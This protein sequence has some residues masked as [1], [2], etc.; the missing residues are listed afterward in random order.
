MKENFAISL[1][2]TLRHEGGYSND[3]HDPGG[4]TMRGVTWREYNRYR[5]AKGLPI[6]PVRECT[7]EEMH[8]IYRR[9]YWD[10]MNCDSLPAGLDFAIFDLAVNNGV[11]RAKQF[12][13]RAMQ[14]TDGS[15]R[16]LVNSICDQRLAFDKGLRIWRVFG[17]GWSR[18][19]AEVRA[20]SLGMAKLSPVPTAEA[21][22]PLRV[23]MI[24]FVVMLLQSKLR[25]KGYPVGGIDGIFGVQTKRAVT[26][27]Q[28]EH[29][30]GKDALGVWQPHY[31][32]L[33]DKSPAL[34]AGR[35]GATEK[36]LHA[37]G[38]SVTWAHRT[39]KSVL[40][41]LGIGA[42]GAEVANHSATVAGV[43]ENAK[44]VIVPIAGAV[45][46]A[47]DHKYLL[48]SIAC[49]SL[50]ALVRYVSYRRV[51]EYKH[52]DTQGEFKEVK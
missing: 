50:F 13:P 10:A 17:R 47:A 51:T 4:A 29:N 43:L 22:A 52:F 14:A 38:D 44:E 27:F 12:L 6:R 48:I 18:R 20:A 23:G 31:M 5:K 15:S 1:Q 25:A 35:Q 41:W 9:N 19:I 26:V 42:G 30:L 33:L 49:A 8:D 39:M 3:K 36:D 45:N 24:G 21:D 32:A 11:G 37:S 16:A 28:G 2:M 7:V 46:W 34:H 40:S